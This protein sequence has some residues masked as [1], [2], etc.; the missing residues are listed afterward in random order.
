MY[1]NTAYLPKIDNS[2]LDEAITTEHGATQGK[3]SSA[4]FYSMYVSDMPE[5]LEGISNYYM[6]PY[7]LLQLA[8]NT[9]TLFSDIKSLKAK[10]LALLK[11]LDKN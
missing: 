6:D 9:A 3:K 2:T 4:N 11:Y 1:E 10:I 8:D 7:N 5:P